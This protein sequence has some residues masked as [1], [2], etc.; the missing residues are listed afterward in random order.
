MTVCEIIGQNIKSVVK[1]DNKQCQRT[2]R[3]TTI[4]SALERVV[5]VFF[6]CVSLR[7]KN[8]YNCHFY[9]NQKSCYARSFPNRKEYLDCVQCRRLFECHIYAF[10]GR[11]KMK[12][13]SC[14]LHS[15]RV[16]ELHVRKLIGVYRFG[17]MLTGSLEIIRKYY[18]SQNTALVP[19]N[20]AVK[21]LLLNY[22]CDTALEFLSLYNLFSWASI[23]QSVS[24]WLY[25]VL[26]N[27]S[28]L[29]SLKIV[30]GPSFMRTLQWFVVTF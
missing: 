12:Y 7:N 17:A 1:N 26:T 3:T 28:K 2:S 29:Y 27:F 10:C 6:F 4:T 24:T 21:S 19:K 15:L 23:T 22:L 8:R 9:V 14:V 18:S 16:I 25:V 30:C 5:Y 11:V 13:G 20:I